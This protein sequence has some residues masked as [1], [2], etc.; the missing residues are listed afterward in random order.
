M[1]KS[2]FA[3]SFLMVSIGLNAQQVS[4]SSPDGNI[5]MTVNNQQQLFYSVAFKGKTMVEDSPI[6]FEFKGEKPMAGDYL[7]LN[8]PATQ[9]KSESWKPAVANK[10]S[11]ISVVWNEATIQLKE[12]EGGCRRLDVNIRVYND[13]VAFRYQL[14]NTHKIGCRELTEEATHFALPQDA[15]VWIA[16]Q[17]G[18]WGGGQ[19]QEFYKMPVD[20]LK[21]DTYAFLPFLVEVDKDAYMAIIDAYLDNY[22]GFFMGTDATGLPVTKLAPLPG[23]D[24]N[25]VKARFDGAL[26]TPWRVLMIGDNL[27]ALIESEIVRAV[28]P[29]CAIEDPSWI[30]PG[31]SAWDHWWS[32]EVKMEMPVIKE[33]IDFAAAQGWP[34]MLIDWKWYG[35][36]NKASSDVKTTAS[37]IDM[38]ELLRYAKEKNVRLWVWMYCTD[39]NNNGDIDEAFALYEKWGLAGIKIDFMNRIDQDMVNWYRMVCRKAAEHHLMVDFHGAY[40]PDGIDRTWPNQMTREGVLGEEYYKWSERMIPE[41]NITLAFIY[42]S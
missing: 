40:R 10:H 21:T 34:F 15:S 26:W 5:L 25:G 22:P 2:L 36:Y 42:L 12:K 16:K 41:H 14:F 33:Y 3:F 28:N 6:S 29:P 11:Q 18:K 8:N 17:K 38:P 19:E 39:V 7:M 30:Q 31:I 23:E 4:V 1:K 32:G 35:D 37:Q 9:S 27:G 20:S 24:E 13:G